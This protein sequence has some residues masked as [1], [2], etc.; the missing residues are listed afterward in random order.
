M[1]SILRKRAQ[2]TV[3]HIVVL[4]ISIVFIFWGVGVYMADA[5]IDQ[6][7][8][9]LYEWSDPQSCLVLNAQFASGN[10]DHPAIQQVLEIYKQMGSTVHL[11]SLERYQELAQ[12][13]QV[14]AGGFVSLLDWHGF[15]P[16]LI[17]EDLSAVGKT[18]VGYGGY[19]LKA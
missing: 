14:D 8:S 9:Y 5:E 1:L 12:P 11:R 6:S 17:G 3:I 16:S 15:D 10:P 4:V 7:L 19:L 18:G 2:S 13:W